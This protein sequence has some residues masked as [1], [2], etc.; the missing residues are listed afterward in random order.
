MTLRRLRIIHIATAFPRWKGDTPSIWVAQMLQQLHR[1]GHE[2]AVFTSS[3][4]GLGHQ[5]FDGIE[6][7]RFRYAP[8]PIETLTH[9]LAVPERLKQSRKYLL[10][11]PPYLIFGLTEAVR[12]AFRKRYDIVHVHWPIPH[13]LFGMP[14][15]SVWKCPIFLYFHGSELNL[16]NKLP[17]PF[18]LFFKTLFKRADGVTVNSNFTKKRTE[19]LELGIPIEVVPFGNPHLEGEMF[20]FHGIE[21]KRILFVGRLIDVKSPQTL[22]MAF[23][24]LKD[25]YPDAT[26]T[27]VG[28]GPLRRTLEE[29][30][31]GLGVSNSVFFKGFLGGRDLETAYLNGDIFVLPSTV[32][33]A[34]HTE[35]LGVVAIE[36]LSYGL[37]VIAS[38][39]GGIPDIVIDGKT[40]LLFQPEN[41][42]ELADKISFLIEHPDFA[43]KLVEQG[44][45]HVRSNFAWDVV[46]DR[47]ERLYYKSIA[48][49]RRF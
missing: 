32:D 23:K 47:L 3:Y 10:L 42:R 2:V 49:R 45:A 46:I 11:I 1:R 4:K 25:R 38:R 7:F 21:K 48:E 29:M 31:E 12:F 6:V 18:K 37:P 15:S 36:A 33:K 20:K 27:F 44:Q 5:I 39:V 26:L 24:L 13:V 19:R 16:L 28:D 14:M 30:A 22:L 41:H 17:D 34:G 43:K 40:G 8:A 35:T 9:E